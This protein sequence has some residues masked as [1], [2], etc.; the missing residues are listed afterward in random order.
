[1]CGSA[2]GAIKRMRKFI[3]PS[4]IYPLEQKDQI[5][6]SW[7]CETMYKDGLVS[8]M[9]GPY[10]KKL[11]RPDFCATWSVNMLQNCVN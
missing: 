1:M 10:L 9:W 6:L 11:I 5:I 4:G 7:L 3:T 8:S 2:R